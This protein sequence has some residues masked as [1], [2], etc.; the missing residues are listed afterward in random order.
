[1]DGYLSRE[2]YPKHTKQFKP[3]QQAIGMLSCVP[4]IGQKR[5]MKALEHNSIEDMI[6]LNEIE[7]LTKTMTAKLK[8]ALGSKIVVE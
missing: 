4:G 8:K 6:G 1:M 3:Y 2:H 7:G 5:A